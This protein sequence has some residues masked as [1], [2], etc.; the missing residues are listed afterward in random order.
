[1]GLACQWYCSLS[2]EVTGLTIPLC[3]ASWICTAR[4]ADAEQCEQNVAGCDQAKLLEG[5]DRLRCDVND[6]H[7]T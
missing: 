4:V 6:F 3:Y 1:M 5:Q 7:V 2:N